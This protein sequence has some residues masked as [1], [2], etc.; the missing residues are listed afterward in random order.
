M[1]LYFTRHGKTEWNQQ[2]RF[3]GMTGD[4]P[5]LP[6]SYEEIR[7]LGNA[8]KDVPFEKIFSSTSLRARETAETIRQMLV[9]PPEIVYTDLLKELGLGKMEGQPIQE[10]QAIYQEEL[11]HMRTR[12]D[13]YN[14]LAFEGEPIQHAIARVTQVVTA[15]VQE[16]TGPFLFVGH[17]ASLTAAIQAMT[18]KTLAQLRDMGGLR[19]N[20]LTILEAKKPAYDLPYSLLLW[21]ARSFLEG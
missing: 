10:M 9:E 3:Q 1:K 20:S 4:S 21:N 18:G 8:L 17:G 7:L 2:K 16:G 11:I 5:L 6:T 14:P 19:N 12:L 13:L 15:A